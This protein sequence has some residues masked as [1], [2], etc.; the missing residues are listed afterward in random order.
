VISGGAEGVGGEIRI[1]PELPSCLDAP[2][3]RDRKLHCQV[4][5]LPPF[6]AI[7]GQIHDPSGHRRGSRP[8]FPNREHKANGKSTGDWD[9]S[10]FFLRSFAICVLLAE[11]H[12]QKKKSIGEMTAQ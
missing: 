3:I 8:N 12:M 11:R 10:V 4:K 6:V 7:R 9:V 1:C 5:R 2:A